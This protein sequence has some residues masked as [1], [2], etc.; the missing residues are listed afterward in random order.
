MSALVTGLTYAS[1]PWMAGVQ[2][3]WANSQGAAQL[4]GLTQRHEF[5]IATGGTYRVAPGLS[6]VA[7]YTYTMRH[8][9]GFNFAANGLG[10]GTTANTA[11]ATRDAMGQGLVL[12]TI[13]TW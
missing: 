5:G 7:E 4:T 10:A 12:A 9:G 3:G 2:L 8:Q 13:L 1:G 6:L 11:G